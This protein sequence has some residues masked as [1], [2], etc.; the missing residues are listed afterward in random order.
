MLTHFRSISTLDKGEEKKKIGKKYATKPFYI[1][2]NF[3]L[4]WSKI[5]SRVKNI[6][7]KF[8]ELLFQKKKKYK[9]NALW[10]GKKVKFWK[11]IL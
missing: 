4:I 3:L 1:I 6:T 8:M 7:K 2:N 9:L 5:L 11:C 10:H